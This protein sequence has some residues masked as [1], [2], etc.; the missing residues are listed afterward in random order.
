MLNAVQMVPA[1]GRMRPGSRPGPHPERVSVRRMQPDDYPMVAE[2]VDAWS[3]GR[4]LGVALPRSFLQ[5]FADTSLL[6]L[7]DTQP[8]GVLVGFRS[9]T[10]AEIAYIHYV[11]ISRAC[12]RRG[13]GRTLFSHFFD[14]AG[15]MGCTEVHSIASPVSSSLIAFHRQIG[16]EV[17][18]GG[19]FA[20]GI[21]V[22]ADYA[23]P[24]Q[25]RVLFRKRLALTQA[26]ALAG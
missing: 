20:H 25:H 24:G 22:F 19:G 14:L 21:A 13:L 8:V 4:F 7:E 16:F 2:R 15:S 10:S 26:H 3:G 23:G 17:V 18:D 9:Q 1:T 11:S 5:H 6:L 12:R